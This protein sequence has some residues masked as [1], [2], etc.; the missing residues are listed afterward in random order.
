MQQ[1]PHSTL[2]SPSFFPSP[3]LLPLTS[4]PPSF[5]LPPY[6]HCHSFTVGELGLEEELF[7]KLLFL[8][9]SPQALLDVTRRR[10]APRDLSTAL[11]TSKTNTL[12]SFARA[13]AIDLPGYLPDTTSEDSISDEDD[14]QISF[15]KRHIQFRN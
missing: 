13:S 8:F 2:P 10:D 4:L 6:S 11:H 7:A 3:S 5:P 1:L 15:I 14:S 9:R 12:R